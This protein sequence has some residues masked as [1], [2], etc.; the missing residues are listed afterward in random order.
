MDSAS[1][2]DLGIDR[3]SVDDRLRLI[4]EICESLPIQALD[5]IPDWHK[6]ILDQRIAEADAHPELFIPWK[7]VLEK[8]LKRA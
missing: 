2:F 7:E 4:G 6:E 3:W 8:L 5:E 1:I